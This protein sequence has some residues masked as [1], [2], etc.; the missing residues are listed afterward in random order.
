MSIENKQLDTVNISL[1]AP[2]ELKITKVRLMNTSDSLL[3][4]FNFIDDIPDM[5]LVVYLQYG[6]APNTKHY[7]MKINISRGENMTMEKNTAPAIS[8]FNATLQRNVT[9]QGNVTFPRNVTFRRNDSI[10]TNRTLERKAFCHI[11][12]SRSFHCY[13]FD[14]FTYGYKKN[15]IVWFATLYEGPMPL[16]RLVS[17]I[18]TFDVKEYTSFMNFSQQTFS[19]S[20]KYWNKELDRFDDDG[21]EVRQYDMI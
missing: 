15:G 16:K 1:R 2:K 8:I 10:Q 12:D 17:N 21:L 4:R 13:N 7:D 6:V 3:V 9:F 20:C 11:I 14:N 18:F 5:R 19:P